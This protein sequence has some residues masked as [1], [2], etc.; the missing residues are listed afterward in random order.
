MTD[1]RRVG[2]DRVWGLTFQGSLPS[3]PVSRN[4]PRGHISQKSCNVNTTLEPKSFAFFT[5]PV[6]KWFRCP[7]SEYSHLLG[8]VGGKEVKKMRDGNDRYGQ[9]QAFPQ[10]VLFQ[11]QRQSPRFYIL[12][13]LKLTVRTHLQLLLFFAIS[14]PSLTLLSFS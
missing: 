9:Y 2:W 11:R 8:S 3:N 6:D 4:W 1:K 14:S 5:I 10:V 12:F 13:Y 7:M